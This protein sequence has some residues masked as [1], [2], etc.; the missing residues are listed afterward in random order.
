M[1]LRDSLL[2]ALVDPSSDL[3]QE[4]EHS[5]P[6]FLAFIVDATQYSAA[7]LSLDADW[8]PWVRPV[9]NFLSRVL[10]LLVHTVGVSFHVMFHLLFFSILASSVVFVIPTRQLLLVVGNRGTQCLF[11]VALIVQTVRVASARPLVCASCPQ[12]SIPASSLAPEFPPG[13]TSAG[14][15]NAVDSVSTAEHAMPGWQPRVLAG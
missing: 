11:M 15:R 3:R 7:A 6:P 4:L 10:L 9:V 2:A 5:L 14:R 8:P 12:P 1:S 13:T